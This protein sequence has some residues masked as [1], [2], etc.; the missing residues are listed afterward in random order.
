MAGIRLV[1]VAR[2]APSALRALF[3]RV[4]FDVL[5]VAVL[6]AALWLTMWRQG[7]D[8]LDPARP[9]ARGDLLVWAAFAANLVAALFLLRQMNPAGGYLHDR[10]VGLRV[11]PGNLVRRPRVPV[12]PEAAKPAARRKMHRRRPRGAVPSYL[13]DSVDDVV[14]E[15]PPRPS[16]VPALAPLPGVDAPAGVDHRG[17]PLFWLAERVVDSVGFRAV[18]PDSRDEPAPPLPWWLRVLFAPAHLLFAVALRLGL[19]PPRT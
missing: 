15:P 13:V 16:P 4:L 7:A 3:H 19:R 8:V 14:R 9:L 17:G 11:V 6:F 5:L 1:T 10:L 18:D 2:A 12:E